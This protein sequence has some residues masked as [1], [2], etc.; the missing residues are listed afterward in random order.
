M[1]TIKVSNAIITLDIAFGCNRQMNSAIG[2]NSFWAIARMLLNPPKVTRIPYLS[3]P[4]LRFRTSH[5][6]FIIVF[7]SQILLLSGQ[8][9]DYVL[10]TSGSHL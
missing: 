9:F 2:M 6:V 7:F 5:T 3:L 1:N 8:R 10:R 4:L